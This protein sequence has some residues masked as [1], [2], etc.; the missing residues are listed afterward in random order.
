MKLIKFNEDAL[1][2][3]VD[4]IER[5]SIYKGTVFYEIFELYD[6][7]IQDIYDRLSRSNK[8]HEMTIT[9]SD[10]IQSH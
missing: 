10:G 8:S 1:V 6:K 4:A 3:I 7:N 5:H 2:A 9:C